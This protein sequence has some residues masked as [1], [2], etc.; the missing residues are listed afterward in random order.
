MATCPNCGSEN[1][2]GAKYCD[3]CGGKIDLA[4]AQPEPVSPSEG[5]EEEGLSPSFD[6]DE[7]DV[8]PGPSAEPEDEPTPEPEPEM[9]PTEPEG[10]PQAEPLE[11]EEGPLE[12]LPRAGYLV[13]PDNSEQPI[14][15][16]QWL[17][18]RADLSK[19]LTDPK[20]ANE[21]SR[22]HLTVFQEGDRFFIE[23]GTTMVQRK[24]S[25][26]KTWLVRDGSRILVTGTGRNELQDA[27]EI[28][29]AE[30]VKLQFVLK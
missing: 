27:D 1:R 28:D 29:V 2:E 16:S 9:E 22:G 20:Q 14:P 17:I 26:N 21:I 8:D 23:D 6:E 3:D 5:A 10:E 24:A 25:S 11:A 7:G 4:I 12:E 15:P 18:G 30:L 13:F 19:F